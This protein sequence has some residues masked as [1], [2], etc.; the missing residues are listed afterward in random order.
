MT[1]GTRTIILANLNQIP[2]DQPEARAR[3][4]V[5]LVMTSPEGAVMK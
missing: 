1:L 3:V 2:A 5:Y 4:A